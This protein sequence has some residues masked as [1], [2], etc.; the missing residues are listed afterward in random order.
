MI[1]IFKDKKDIPQD[2][3]YMKLNDVFSNQHTASA[4]DEQA[5]DGGL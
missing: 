5:E 2:L 4:L 1:T 3:E